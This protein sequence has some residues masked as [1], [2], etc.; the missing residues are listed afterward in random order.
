M[1]FWLLFSFSE[2]EAIMALTLIVR[3]YK[4]SVDTDKVPEVK[5]E[6]KLER[7]ERL[8]ASRP[9]FTLTPDAVPLVFT[10]RR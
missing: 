9:V 1:T 8:L 6:S 10:R 5:G 4:I 3:R 2:V 7:R